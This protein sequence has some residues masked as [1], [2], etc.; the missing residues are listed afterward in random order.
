[1]K[2]DTKS[3]TNA[4]SA[5]ADVLVYSFGAR[6]DREAEDAAIDQIIK[7]RR[8]YN[9]IIAKM[10]DIYAEAQAFMISKA[11]AGAAALQGA[12]DTL[13]EQ[14]AQAKA[15]S[16]EP[17]MRDIAMQ[18]REKWRDLG[19]MM[20]AI[21]KEH[22]THINAT[23]WARIGNNRSC[24]TYLERC[25]AVDAGLGWGTASDVL[26]RALT[27]WKKSMALGR[28]P[29][30]SSAADKLS[31]SLTLQFTTPGGSPIDRLM[32][33]EHREVS[34]VAEAAGRRCYGEFRFRLG[35][36]SANTYATG[37]WIYHREIPAGATASLVRLVRTREANKFKWSIQIVAK[38]PAPIRLPTAPKRTLAC[39]H[40][41]WSADT[42][43]RRVAGIADSADPGLARLVQ[44]PESI[45]EDLVRADDVKSDRD[46]ALNAVHAH[47]K[48]FVLPDG[49]PEEVAD[50]LLAVRRLSAS[51]ISQR[52]ARMLLNMLMK[53]DITFQELAAWASQDK[54][55][56]QAEFGIAK[57]ARNRRRDHYRQ[58]AI[59]LA[60]DYSAVALEPLDLA[61]AAIKVN[62]VTGE[63]TEFNAKARSGRVVAAIYEFEQ[64]IRWACA[65]HATAVFDLH[66][67]PTVSTCP[68]CGSDEV[69]TAAADHRLISCRA[70][71]AQEDRKLSGAAMAWQ[72]T[73]D[74]INDRIVDWH[75]FSASS[76]EEAKDASSLRKQK[77]A[78]GRRAKIAA[79]IGSDGGA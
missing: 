3:I 51:H 17:A 74:G 44:L 50:E 21:R 12:I 18:R 27:A 19:V 36:A 37:T 54:K 5:H 1:M 61:A 30:F 33:K 20:A 58:V 38:L 46:K 63:K 15:E 71:G 78:D 26:A 41:G 73:Q 34:L 68:H 60:R 48:A 76:R 59:G 65:K 77:M 2:H 47:I 55:Q 23:Y 57:R 53:Y 70:C 9:A 35:A 22:R 4:T 24:D 45:E 43:G 49:A 69:E 8:L 31:D 13:S 11:P 10:R 28:P 29:Q 64:A 79:R 40:F 6:I 39:V 7:A 75:A 52:R 62:E 32:T 67:M 16:D 25:A 14:F 42:T 72:F 56:W 66:G